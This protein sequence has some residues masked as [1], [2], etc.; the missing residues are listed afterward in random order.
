MPVSL[1][2]QGTIMKDTI[3]EFKEK[4]YCVVKSAITEELR[5][6]VTQY[7]L[8][9]ESQ[10]FTK[11]SDS[12]QGAQVPA[13]HSRYADAGMETMLLHL[14]ETMEENTGLK[15]L[16]TYSYYRVYRNGDDLKP[17]KDRPSCEISATLCFNYSY[18]KKTYTWPIFMDGSEVAIEPGDMVI[19]RGCDLE[20]YRNAFSCPE[21]A[22]HV[23]GFFHYVD[24]NGPHSE[25]KYDKRNSIGEIKNTVKQKRVSPKSYIIFT[26][27]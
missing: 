4:G 6:F 14:H 16:P 3:K 7:S 9:D 10:N 26:K 15:L 23:Q 8:F 13:A 12:M 27:E 18:D 25:W 24:A 11:E 2:P 21:Q 5:D 19:Y 20:H 22:W 17:H 1:I